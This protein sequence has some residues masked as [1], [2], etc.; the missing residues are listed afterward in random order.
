MGLEF[1]ADAEQLVAE[2]I[3]NYGDYVNSAMARLYRFMGMATMEWTGQGARL[4]DVY[5]NE[6]INCAGNCVFFHGHSHP[7][8]VA[9]VKQQL[10]L[11]PLSS[12]VLPHGP[13]AK[14]GK[15]L[16]EITP[17]KLQ[18]SFFCNSGTEAVE[19]ALK[20]ARAYTGKS[21]VVAA[22]GGFHGKTFGS[23]SASGRELYREPFYPLLSGFT[24]VPFGDAQAL[25]E[26]ITAEIGAV[27]LEPIQGEGGVILP[28]DD[29]LAQVRA[30]CDRHGLLLILDEVTCG[31]GRTGAW[32]GCDHYG[33]EPDIMC[34]AKALGG[35]VMPIGAFIAR[36]EI[37]E[38]FDANP[39]IHSSTFGGNP[40]ACSAA[41]AAITVIKE[42]G[43]VEQAAAK[44]AAIIA[45]LQDLQ[46]EFP[47]VI[48]E[49]R[50]K[51]LLIGVEM[52]KEGAGGLIISELLNRQVL[53][54]HSLNNAKVIRLLPPAVINAEEIQQVL[55]AFRAAVATANTVIADL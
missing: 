11:L 22:Y 50:G 9:A 20:L 29:Y 46:R 10:D 40:L 33:V 4:I 54:I 24:H 42:E 43:L 8:V 13:I 48:A 38:L 30:I 34:L 27:I 32:F 1:P 52:A 5:G 17:G 18:Y 23:L 55:A 28:P 12:R 21:G 44:G 19:G 36:P 31:L 51:G 15:M 35:G 14:L 49:V 2:T 7:Q 47:D 41:I 39:Y 26:A 6:Y 53:A 37:F 25:E 3:S 16:A 45:Y